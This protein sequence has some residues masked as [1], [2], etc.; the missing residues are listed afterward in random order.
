MNY[1]VWKFHK[2]QSSQKKVIKVETK[3]EVRF[4]FLIANISRTV[5]IVW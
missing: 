3:P 2:N 5:P 4:L 1:I